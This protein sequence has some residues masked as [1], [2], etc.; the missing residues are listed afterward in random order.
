MSRRLLNASLLRSLRVA[1]ATGAPEQKVPGPSDWQPAD[2]QMQGAALNRPRRTRW[3]FL[4]AVS[5]CS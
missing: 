3:L 1:V 2:S 5:H 4:I